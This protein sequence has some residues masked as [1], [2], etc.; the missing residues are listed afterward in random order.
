MKSLIKLGFKF[1]FGVII[2]A[3]F[4]Y[5]GVTYVL[6]RLEEKEKKDWKVDNNYYPVTKVFDG[7]TFE[8]DINGKKEKVRMLAIDTPEKWES[9]KLT[10]DAER[11]KSDKKTIQKLGDL[12][13]RFTAK[14][15][16]GK[17]VRL[18]A[19]PVNDDKDKYGR[20]LRYVYLDDGTF[21]NLKIVE[22]G[23]ANAYTRF[24]LSKKDEFVNAEK[25]ARDN[26]KG[27]W[28]DVEGLKYMGEK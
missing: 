5:F 11:T 24:P 19:D 20:L 27:L 9:D 28:G 25:K 8:T 7:D 15:I 6:P 17:K 23:Y 12:S 16:E 13:F 2:I 14:L 3:A 10:K 1:I 18:A 4:V 26:K 22:E 21:V